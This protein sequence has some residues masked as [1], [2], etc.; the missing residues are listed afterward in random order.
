MRSMKCTKCKTDVP[1]SARF[2]P[3]CG[4]QT[5]SDADA[6]DAQDVTLDWLEAVYK[7]LGYKTEIK[8]NN[9]YLKH[10][11]KPNMWI[12]IKAGGRFIGINS[13]WVSKRPGLLQKTTFL[14]A[15]NKANQRSFLV[16]F[17]ADLENSEGGINTSTFMWLG[18]RTSAR[19]IADF[20]DHYAQQIQASFDDSGLR[21]FA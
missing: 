14:A 13:S 12:Q 19:D 18:H 1:P 20:T 3:S 10:D 15:L 17:S 6:K 21:A 2:C 8:E 5:V 16:N 11:N 9:L 4:G 7:E